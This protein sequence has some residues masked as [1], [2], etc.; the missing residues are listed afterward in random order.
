[1]TIVPQC[2]TLEMAKCPKGIHQLGIS[3]QFTK[4]KKLNLNPDTTR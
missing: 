2:H 3:L 1:M 4:R